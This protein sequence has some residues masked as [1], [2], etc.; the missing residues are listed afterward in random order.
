MFVLQGKNLEDKL[1]RIENDLKTKNDKINQKDILI[2]KKEQSIA[3]LSQIIQDNQRSTDKRDTQ[4]NLNGI[5]KINKDMQMIRNN[6]KINE[7]LKIN[8]NL[9]EN[10]KVMFTQLNIEGK[11]LIDTDDDNETAKECCCEKLKEIDK[12]KKIISENK[13]VML[14]KSNYSINDHSM[15]EY[16]R[17]IYDLKDELMACH[18]ENEFLEMIVRNLR[19]RLTFNQSSLLINSSIDVK[20]LMKENT[21]NLLK[22]TNLKTTIKIDKESIENYKKVINKL[23]MELSDVDNKFLYSNNDNLIGKDDDDM[24]DKLVLK[25]LEDKLK[26]SKEEKK[27]FETQYESLKNN[28]EENIN[29]LKIK[30]K[31]IE[32]KYL[33]TKNLNDKLKKRDDC[34]KLRLEKRKKQ[35]EFLKNKYSEI[36]QHYQILE[37]E[38]ENLSYINTKLKVK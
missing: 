28:Y 15:K 20:N 8:N 17:E 6:E 32:K 25:K 4:N 7:L 10:L 2:K 35:I 33:I 9:K 5:E 12:L 30:L 21:E 16:E 23:Q 26:L 13:I 11:R 27:N 3:Q 38:M 24:N 29:S 36:K 19:E 14:R 18:Q 31:D 37:N 1:I 22:I 34:S